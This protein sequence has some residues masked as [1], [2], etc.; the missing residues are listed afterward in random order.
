MFLWKKNE[1]RDRKKLKAFLSQI[2]FNICPHYFSPMLPKI[3]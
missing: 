3:D 2:E 1:E